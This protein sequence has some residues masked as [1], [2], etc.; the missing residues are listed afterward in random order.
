MST[1]PPDVDKAQAVPGGGDTGPPQ[2]TKGKTFAKQAEVDLEAADTYQDQT[3]SSSPAGNGFKDVGST[4]NWYHKLNPLRWQKTPPLP[5]RRQENREKKAGLLSVI[6]FHWVAPLMTVGN[7]L[8]EQTGYLRTLELQDIWLVHPDRELNVLSAKLQSNFQ[9]LIEQGSRHPILWA[10]Y[11][12]FKWDFIIGGCCGLVSALLQVFTPYT[13]RYLISFATEAWISK[14]FHVPGPHIGRGIGLVI[15]ICLMQFTQSM[16][17]NQFFYRGMIVGG[18]ARAALI[19]TIFL[20]TTKISSRA[21]AGGKALPG[22][23]ADAPGDDNNDDLG[24]VREARDELQQSQNRSSKAPQ[25]KADGIAGDGTGWSNGRI[26]T[27]MSIDTDRIDKAFGLF[28]LVWTSPIIIIVA[29]IMLLVNIGYS[30]LSGYALLFICLPLLSIAVKS[31]FRRRMKINKVTDQRV[32]LTQEILQAVRFVKYFSWESSFARRLKEL[33]A[34]EIRKIQVVQSIR[35]GLMCVALSLPVFASMISFITYA[36]SKHDMNAAFVFSSLAIFNTLRQPLNML[37]LTI[38]QLTDAWAAL[39]RIQGF[40]LAEEQEE[41]I[42]Q[43]PS[44]D[45][46]IE[47]SDATFTWERTPTDNETEAQKKKKAKKDRKPAAKSATPENISANAEGPP[48]KLEDLSLSLKRDELVAVIGTV[49]CGKT[50]LLSALAGDMRMTKG[51]ARMNAT[52]AYCPQYAWIQNATVKENILFG[53]PY[54]EERYNK[55]I[56]ACALKPDIEMFDAGDDTEIGER[57]ITL[58][59][60]QKQRLNIARAMYFSADLVL[61]DDPLSAVDAHV[62]RHIMDNAICGLLKGT[63]RVLATHQLHVLSRCDR[64]LLMDQGKIERIGTF[65]ELMQSSETFR[66]LMATTSQE[67]SQEE[68]GEKN[69]GDEISEGDEI[70]SSGEDEEDTK[71]PAKQAGTLMQ[72]EDRGTNSV[73][74]KIWIAY[75]KAFGRFSFIFNIPMILIT[76]VSSNGANIITG[77]WLSWWTS[78]NFNLSQ[79]QYMGLYAGLGG[80]QVFLMF[81]LSTTVSMSTTNASRTMF[82]RAMTRVLRAPM[83]FFDTTPLG[84]ITNRFSKDIHTM[85]NELTDTMRIALLTV[86]MIVA[87]IILIIVIFHWFAL[88]LVPLLIVLVFSTMFYRRS[89]RELKRHES[90]L[91]STVFAQFSESLTGI[92]SIR[93]YGMQNFFVNR[94][95]ASLDDM[96]SAYF[97]T[98]ANQRWLSVRLDAVGNL[99]VFVTGI[100]VVTSRFDVSPSTSGLVL[101]Y[102]LSIVG[103]LQFTVRE[104]AELENHMNATERVHGYA[105]SLQVEAPLHTLE[106][107]S[108]WPQA[109]RIKFEN[110][111]MRYRPGLP[112]VLKGLS[113]DVQGGEKIGIVGRTG[114]GK[115]SIMS[116][117]FRLSELDGGQITIDGIDILKIGLHDLRSRLAIIPQDPTLFRGTIRSNLDPFEEHTDLELWHA[118]RKAGLADEQPPSLSIEE[119]STQPTTTQTKLHLDSPVE[120]DGLNYSL[121]QRQLMALARALVRDSRIIVCDEATSSVDFETDQRIQRTIAQGFTGKTLLCIAHR[122]RTIIHYDRICV[123]DQG[124]IAEM[125]HPL[126]L[127]SRE[128]S[129]FRG[130]CD[131]S[132]ITREDFD[133]RV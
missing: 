93:A 56:E 24:Q 62:G 46:M 98:F 87:I 54:D 120:E 110:V 96:D 115:S 97:L 94:L 78:D 5:D 74:W 49:G 58:S 77:L 35:N 66:R 44:L 89:A 131:R 112:L 88:A 104:V 114:A 11:Y 32:S 99:M 59:G 38:S 129:I 113:M 16:T 34:E 117:L 70:G 51:S 118:L 132:G 31:L 90:V 107:D 48:F 86:S 100:L 79:G 109:G 101:S 85:D 124:E 91:R 64:I 23:G 122:L 128:S 12:T 75:L 2:T 95:R 29:L 116:A 17:M 42:T 73:S 28:H 72:Q 40:L 27:L 127:W 52:R 121:G 92:P 61:L 57:G 63:C 53:K 80:I 7:P 69:G 108:S 82:T 21:R 33:R 26:I 45:S 25:D 76:I 71:G 39:Q 18:Q 106:V 65:D 55:V 119:D 84:R 14:H 15:G 4:R 125:D 67:A 20:K 10:L 41:T 68:E 36:L 13:T 22:E 130:M 30:C 43:D 126:A 103:M 50:S 6:T 123:V 83:S 47:I 19:D 111:Q 8:Y 60:G 1:L 9:R 102:I 105:T 37:P 81:L 3:I 133:E